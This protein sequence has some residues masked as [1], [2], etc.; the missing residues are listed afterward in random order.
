VPGSGDRPDP[1]G[2]GGTDA[3]LMLPDGSDAV[4][5]ILSCMAFPPCSTADA[6]RT[7][8]PAAAPAPAAAPDA[9]LFAVIVAPPPADAADALC[10]DGPE[11][12]AVSDGD[13]VARPPVV[14][15]VGGVED[16]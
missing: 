11:T 2:D 4:D 6:A 9:P 16:V 8:G 12:L 7:A 10:G 1:D 14:A 5:S 3:A 15:P 13:D